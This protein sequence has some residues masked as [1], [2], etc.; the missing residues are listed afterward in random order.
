MFSSATLG[1]PG[2]AA[3]LALDNSDEQMYVAN[4]DHQK[5]TPNDRKR[6]SMRIRPSYAH[7]TGLPKLVRNPI[8]VVRVGNTNT[9]CLILSMVQM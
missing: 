6:T 3:S 5:E 4:P 9:V 1:Y 2:P 8:E 7:P